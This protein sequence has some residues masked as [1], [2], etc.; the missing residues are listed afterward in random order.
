MKLTATKLIQLGFLGLLLMLLGGYLN[1]FVMRHNHNKMPVLV[2]NEWFADSFIDDP[3]H[4][5]LDKDSRDILL[6]DIIPLPSVRDTGIQ[7][8]EMVSFGDF[9]IYFGWV[10]VVLAEFGFV[11]LPVVYLGRLIAIIWSWLQYRNSR[12]PRFKEEA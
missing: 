12:V 5:P 1:Q 6:A 8:I 7:I 10:I 2:L 9:V 3:L 4:I 11:F